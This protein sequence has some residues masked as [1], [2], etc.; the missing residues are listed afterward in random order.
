MRSTF[1]R[2]AEP[3]SS[4]RWVRCLSVS[5]PASNSRRSSA[6]ASRISTSAACAS[7]AY[8]S[9]KRCQAPGSKA[10]GRVAR[11]RT[12]GL[13]RALPDISLLLGRWG[14]MLHSNVPQE[15]P[16]VGAGTDGL[17]VAAGRLFAV[18]SLDIRE[19]RPDRRC[20]QARYTA[21]QLFTKARILPT[22]REVAR[23]VG[24]FSCAYRTERAWRAPLGS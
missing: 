17:T 15:F 10:G 3:R 8:E 12:C 14:R 22:F 24:R 19:Y 4:A 5:A 2:G 20:R 7:V 9:S 23:S 16:R 6:L 13:W 11:P 21:N 1:V 18:F